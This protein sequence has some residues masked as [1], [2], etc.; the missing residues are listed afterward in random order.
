MLSYIPIID[1][2]LINLTKITIK[3]RKILYDST[4]LNIKI[5][6][7]KILLSY[8]KDSIKIQSKILFELRNFIDDLYKK[9]LSEDEYS[10]LRSRPRKVNG[11]IKETNGEIKETNGEIKEINGEI[12]REINGEI[13]RVINND[14]TINF[15]NNHSSSTLIPS[16]NSSNQIVKIKTKDE[17]YKLLQKYYP[18]MNTNNINYNVVGDFILKI[19]ISPNNN[20][21]SFLIF[22]SEISYEFNK[23]RNT[24]YK[25]TSNVKKIIDLIEI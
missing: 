15:I 25:N 1:L 18:Y 7:A 17:F 10:K 5:S 19:F 9:M 2:E 3:D 8:N 14:V 23:K 20:F 21:C 4:E 13:N 24:I 12:N 6:S 22:D 16:N 11:V